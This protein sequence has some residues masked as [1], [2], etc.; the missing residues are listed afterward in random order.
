MRVLINA[1]SWRDAGDWHG[2]DLSSEKALVIEWALRGWGWRGGEFRTSIFGTS[3]DDSW[4]REE[5]DGC[6]VQMELALAM[7]LGGGR[8]WRGA[9]SIWAA[10][11][12]CL[13]RGWFLA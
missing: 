1:V 10:V 2:L 8:E 7:G 5:A 11:M 4:A 6:L 12:Q 9:H 3:S 13:G